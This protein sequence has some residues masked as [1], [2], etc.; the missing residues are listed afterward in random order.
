MKVSSADLHIHTV[1]SP[2]GSLDMSPKN[3]VQRAKDSHLDI[4]GITDHNS[5]RH[6]RIIQQLAEGNNIFV[7]CGAEVNSV[8]EVHCLCFMP[9]FEKLD[10]LQSYLD[11][12]LMNSKND[13]EKFGYQVQVDEND[14]IVYEEEKLLIQSINQSI[15]QIEA[16]VH[17]HGGLFIPAHVNRAAFSLIS[18][19]GFIPDD[20]RYDALEI[21]KHIKKNDFLNTQCCPSGI[22]IIQNSDA[23][24]LPDIGSVRNYFHIEKPSFEEIRMALQKTDGR[25]VE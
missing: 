6:C 9:D 21:S 25:F 11:Q 22:S 15:N 19:L 24:F 13:P 23:H 7:L 10:L 14:F 8:E 3:I 4:I 12:Y 5:T 1:L 20:L 2:C 17:S 16:F 18:Q